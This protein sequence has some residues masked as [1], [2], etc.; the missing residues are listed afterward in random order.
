MAPVRFGR[1]GAE[2]RSDK[3]SRRRTARQVWREKKR[4][5]TTARERVAGGDVRELG[6]QITGVV[7]G[8]H[9]SRCTVTDERGDEF[10]CVWTRA[11]LGEGIETPVVGD[12]VSAGVAADGTGVLARIEPRG[13]R[14]ARMRLVNSD[15]F[16][17]IGE[18]QVLAAN[19]DVA[20]IVV[21]AV[22]PPF[23]P[24]LVDRYLVLCRHGGIDP[25][26]C[27][28]KADLADELP[29]L[30]P[31]E[32]LGVETLTTSA[33]TGAGIEGLRGRLRSKWA[34]LT[35]ASG[36][37]KSS[38]LNA[39]TAR[40]EPGS[41]SEPAATA[42]V[43]AATGRGRHRTSASSLIRLGEDTVIIDTPGIRSLSVWQIERESLRL[44]FPEFDAVTL[45]CRFNDCLH[46]SEPDCGVRAGLE[47]GEVSGERYESYLRM[48]E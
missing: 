16:A 6:R 27:L 39:L 41:V 19:V 33:T 1:G 11:A 38:L 32:R 31:W 9:K 28:N 10:S 21:A 43:S 18:E 29:D 20:V 47:N 30:S 46:V 3:A 4:S 48:L 37:G 5:H 26:L 24:R 45:A 36:V 8:V 22:S 34:V 15:R 42:E 7:S 44:Y 40:F 17:P 2:D 13:G 25:L 14:L 35:G 12:R 23:H